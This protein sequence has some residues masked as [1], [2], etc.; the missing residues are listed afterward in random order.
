MMLRVAWRSLMTRPVRTAVLAAGFGFGVAV[1]AELLGVGHVILE[2]ARSPELNGQ[3]NVW[4]FMR[5]NW[6]SNRVFQCFD[7]IV[8]HCC[9]AWNTLIEQPWKIMSL[10]GREWARIGQPI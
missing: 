6:L 8:G 9:D 4:Q 2:Q 10:A 1:M 5:Q 3:E 7:D